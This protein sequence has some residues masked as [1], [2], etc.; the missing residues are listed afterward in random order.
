MTFNVPI[1]EYKDMFV[2]DTV[3]LSHCLTRLT[4]NSLELAQSLTYI[5]TQK[6]TR[7]LGNFPFAFGV[8][9]LLSSMTMCFP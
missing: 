5:N 9:F 3:L 2:S 4:L 7:S 6:E 8:E 1:H